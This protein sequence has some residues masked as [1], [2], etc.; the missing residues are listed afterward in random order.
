MRGEAGPTF[1]DARN[2]AVW[3]A[4]YKNSA[5]VFDFHDCFWEVHDLVTGLI[6][7]E[8]VKME[9]GG[10]WNCLFIRQPHD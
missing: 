3:F 1:D 2:V 10:A 9:D 4:Y 7:G 8:E 6:D 5:W